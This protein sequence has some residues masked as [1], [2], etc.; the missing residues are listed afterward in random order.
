[1]KNVLIAMV[2]WA[3][4]V[5][6]QESIFGPA[7]NPVNTKGNDSSSVSVGTRFASGVAGSVTGVRAYIASNS[8]GAHTVNLWSASGKSLA[9]ATLPSGTGWQ[10]ASF[11]T[12]APITANSIYTVSVLTTQYPW[13]VGY[14][15]NPVKSGDLTAP[16]SAGVYTYSSRPAFPNQ[17][18]KGQYPSYFVDVLFV[19]NTTPPPPLTYS[20]SG[21]VGVSQAVLTLTGAATG[22]QMASTSGFYEFQGLQPGSY[23]IKPT[24]PG[25]TFIPA[26]LSESITTA[27]ITNANF[28]P[29]VNPPPPMH[30][31]T[32]TWGPSTPNSPATLAGYNILRGN[33]VT[34][35]FSAVNS[36]LVLGT[37]YVDT[38]V[39][40]GEVAFYEAVGVD[41]LGQSSAPS[42]VVQ[43]VTPSP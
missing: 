21:N 30:S 11:S 5:L 39:T 31:T 33:S 3:L 29:T 18:W 17:P 13:T 14:F 15:R 34:G 23:S 38:T 35:P 26:S 19:P 43:A 16:T 2:L 25:V 10:S 12:P 37:T 27:N 8:K 6:A 32:L 1:M 22:T 4:P 24:S 40:G 41:S 9:T 36:G 42:N 20:I 7:V 28:A